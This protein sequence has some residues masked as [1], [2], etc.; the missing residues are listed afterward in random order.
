[1]LKLCALSEVYIHMSD[2]EKRLKHH[3]TFLHHQDIVDICKPLEFLN[4]TSFSNVRVSSEQ[5]FTAIS[6][7]PGFA[8]NYILKGVL[9]Q[10]RQN[11]R[12]V[13]FWLYLKTIGIV[14]DLL[15]WFAPPILNKI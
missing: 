10:N 5:S 4:I 12:L 6:S 14:I 7:N 3:P 11:F 13:Y 9:A 8:R 15:R 1:M 2:H